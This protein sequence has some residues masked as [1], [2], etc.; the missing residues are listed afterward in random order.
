AE[1]LSPE[2][3]V[4]GFNFD[5]SD[6]RD[7]YGA[8]LDL[9]DELGSGHTVKSITGY[10]TTDAVYSNATDYLPVDIV[11]IEYTDEYDV[12]SQEFQFIS[13]A[14]TAFNYTAGLYYYKQD[15]NTNRDVVLGSDFVEYFIG[16]LYASGQLSPPLPPAPALPNEVVSQLIEFGPPLSK[17]FNRGEVITTSYAAYFNG[18]YDMTDRLTLGFGA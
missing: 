7:V 2:M 16:P 13:S 11:S 5:H 8:H 15:A 1:Q 9:A 14:D 3:G 10:R 18:A 17:V 12:L 6:E 4:V